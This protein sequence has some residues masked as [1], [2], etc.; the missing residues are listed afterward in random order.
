MNIWKVEYS[1]GTSTHVHD[2]LTVQAGTAEAAISKV[3]R[4]IRRDYGR[5]LTV[6]SVSWDSAVDVQ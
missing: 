5:A 3:R 6:R 2:R 4:R 1:L